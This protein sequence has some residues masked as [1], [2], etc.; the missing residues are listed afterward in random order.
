MR[1]VDR[2]RWGRGA[3]AGV[4]RGEVGRGE[5]EGDGAGCSAM[6]LCGVKCGGVGGHGG[7]G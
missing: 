3:W 1:H 5:V 2:M 6:G 7:A 4:R